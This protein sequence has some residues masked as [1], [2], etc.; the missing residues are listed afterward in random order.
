[1]LGRAIIVSLAISLA[2]CNLLGPGPH[3]NVQTA[4]VA[5]T[6]ST[7]IAF[8]HGFV[9][10][11]PLGF[12]ATIVAKLLVIYA[13]SPNLNEPDRRVVDAAAAILWTGAAAHNTALVLGA[14]MP[15]SAIIG[16]AVGLVV[17]WRHI[18]Q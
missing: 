15:A 12:P 11:N 17:A 9:E 10:A 18:T 4:A 3:P 16:S 13:I 6:A 2:G 8:E 5:D 7:L 1:M 14:A